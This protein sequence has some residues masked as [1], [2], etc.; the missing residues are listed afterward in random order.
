MFQATLHT[1]ACTNCVAGCGWVLEIGL[2][3]NGLQLGHTL[4]RELRGCG[5][6][7][8]ISQSNAQ[9]DSETCSHELR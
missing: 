3:K 9:G 4:L 2:N 6:R 1:D 5:L 7:H 8:L